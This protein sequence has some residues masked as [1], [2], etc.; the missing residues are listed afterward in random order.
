MIKNLDEAKRVLAEILRMK[1]GKQ[2][3][4]QITV[5]IAKCGD[6]E[7]R[8]YLS[9]A[10]HKILK[11]ASGEYLSPMGKKSASTPN[12]APARKKGAPKGKKSASAPNA[13]PA[14]KMGSPKG[15]KPPAPSKKKSP[16]KPKMAPA[17]A[18]KKPQKKLPVKKAVPSTRKEPSPSKP[19][20]KDKSTPKAKPKRPVIKA[21][22]G[23]DSRSRAETGAF[24]N[25]PPAVEE[26]E[27]DIPV[28]PA[29]RILDEDFFSPYENLVDIENLDVMPGPPPKPPPKRVKPSR[30]ALTAKPEPKKPAKVS[31]GGKAKT[32]KKKAKKKAKPA[33]VPVAEKKPT[34]ARAFPLKTPEPPPPPEPEPPA[35]MDEAS[36]S[37][38][39]TEPDLFATIRNEIESND[40]PDPEAATAAPPGRG[41]SKRDE[42]TQT[43]SPPPAPDPVVKPPQYPRPEGGTREW[44]RTPREPVKTVFRPVPLPR[45]KGGKG[46]KAN[47]ENDPPP[48]A[49]DIA[50][51]NIV[52]PSI[53]PASI[54]TP[55]NPSPVDSEA[56]RIERIVERRIHVGQGTEVWLPSGKRRRSDTPPAA[57]DASPSRGTEKQDE[58]GPPETRNEV[59]GPETSGEV[60]APIEEETPIEADVPPRT[61]APFEAAP[62]QEV[63]TDGEFE[64]I[65]LFREMFTKAYRNIPPWARGLTM[66]E[67]PGGVRRALDRAAGLRAEGD[68]SGCRERLS[69]L[70]QETLEVKVKHGRTGRKVQQ[71]LETIARRAGWRLGGRKVEK[72]DLDDGVLAVMVHEPF[73]SQCRELMGGGTGARDKAPGFL[74]IVLTSSSR[75]FRDR[76]E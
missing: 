73:M 50:A 53:A 6:S 45:G 76:K 23:K 62:P 61:G 52:G 9:D 44:I 28:L 25:V 21:V 71:F 54:P 64:T 22:G 12:V 37:M 24:E 75:A 39:I 67:D 2:Q 42:P 19:E 8:K 51:P 33:P 38:V 72:S 27:A 63:F 29:D 58:S 56:D 26:D 46:P 74:E 15:R 30:G 59:S 48:S 16:G 49:E 70:Y 18:K 13:V 5:E 41:P 10:R 3:L 60:E 66:R 40:G 57:V 17:Q 36:P 7:A 20:A 11:L 34:G 4:V 69:R 32:P 55:E 35:K 43:D 14:R 47:Q 31:K 68:E 65:D 1:E